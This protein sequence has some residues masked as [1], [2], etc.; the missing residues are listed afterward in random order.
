MSFRHDIDHVLGYVF[1]MGSFSVR[2]CPVFADFTIL[3]V[4]HLCP[5]DQPWFQL[6]GCGRHIGLEIANRPREPIGRNIVW[7]LFEFQIFFGGENKLSNSIFNNKV[8][9]Y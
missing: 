5:P 7:A 8:N 2:H 4:F 6:P 9:D 3:R 1:L